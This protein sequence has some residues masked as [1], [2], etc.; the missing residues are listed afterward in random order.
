MGFGTALMPNESDT[1][2][3]REVRFTPEF[4]RNLRQLCSGSQAPAW[5]PRLASS[6][7]PCQ[8]REA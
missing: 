8:I 4:K 6:S 1:P 5:E 2:E 3:P 7:L